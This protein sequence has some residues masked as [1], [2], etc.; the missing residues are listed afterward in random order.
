MNKRPLPSACAM[1][2]TLRRQIEEAYAQGDLPTALALSRQMDGVQL[3][4][5][6]TPVSQ[7]VTG[8]KS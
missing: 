4:H 3:R 8:R 7:G 6:Q 2:M 5:W 1:I